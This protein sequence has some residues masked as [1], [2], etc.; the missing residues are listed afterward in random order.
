MKKFT[1]QS[2][3]IIRF[4][5]FTPDHRLEVSSS[6]EIEIVNDKGENIIDLFYDQLEPLV[7]RMRRVIALAKRKHHLTEEDIAQIATISQWAD[8]LDALV[9]IIGD[10]Q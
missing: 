9:K 8:T 7:Q 2:R 1:I 4:I 6:E 3:G 10:K 5:T